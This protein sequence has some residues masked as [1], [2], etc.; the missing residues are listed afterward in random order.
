MSK[1]FDKPIVIQ[2]ID[3]KTESWNDLYTP[4]ASINK[5]KADSEYLNAGASRSKKTLVFEIRYFKELEDIDLNTQRYRILY[6]DTPYN[7]GDYD[8]YM[9]EHKTVKLLGVSY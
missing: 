1:V 4:H 3:E 8:D 9:Q 5:S 2:K 6:R 7:I